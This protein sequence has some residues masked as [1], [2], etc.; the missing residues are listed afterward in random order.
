M[1]VS[2]F[3]VSLFAQLVIMLWIYCSVNS[4]EFQL[5]HYMSLRGLDE[6]EDKEF[7]RRFF[8]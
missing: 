8:S 7:K 1:E 3:Y 2:L 6:K 4:P 5:E